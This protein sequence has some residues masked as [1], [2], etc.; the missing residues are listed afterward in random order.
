MQQILPL[1]LSISDVQTSNKYIPTHKISIYIYIC[2]L[3][4]ICDAIYGDLN[5]TFYIETD[6]QNIVIETER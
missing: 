3:T 6:I 1:T 5:A 4:D 2:P